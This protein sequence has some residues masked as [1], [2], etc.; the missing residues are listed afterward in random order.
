LQWTCFITRRDVVVI[1]QLLEVGRAY[2]IGLNDTLTTA[3]YL[4]GGGAATVIP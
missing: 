3:R 1:A 4:A 2:P